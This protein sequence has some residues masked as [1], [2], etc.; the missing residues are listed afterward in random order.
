MNF[1][2]ALIVSHQQSSRQELTHEHR[3]STVDK[4][5]VYILGFAKLRDL[6]NR[7]TRVTTLHCILGVQIRSRCSG[8]H[9]GFEVNIRYEN[10]FG[11]QEK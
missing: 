10:G 6:S 2:V 9:V 1:V 4:R 11:F 8:L 7:I 3:Y 5:E